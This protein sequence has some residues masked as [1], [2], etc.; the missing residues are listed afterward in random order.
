MS[1]FH[2][3]LVIFIILSSILAI[4]ANADDTTTSTPD[5]Q[6][7]A[8]R[9]IVVTNAPAP[10][11]FVPTPAGFDNCFL[12]Q[13]RWKQDAWVT[14]H[15]ICQYKNSTEGVAWVDGHWNCTDATTEGVCSQWDWVAGHWEKTLEKF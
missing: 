2:F 10:K 1:R 3:Q 11:E 15:K 5:T 4:N 8:P 14:A 7:D 6:T 12:V 9:H 13:A